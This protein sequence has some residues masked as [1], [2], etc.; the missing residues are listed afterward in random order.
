MV[1]KIDREGPVP[2]SQQLANHLRELILSGAI[3]VGRRIPSLMEL[4]EETGLAR[5]TIQ[6][7]TQV[8]KDEGLIETV[9]GMGLYVVDQTDR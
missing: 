1:I 2:P 6:K 8:L 3:P 4:E 7:A 9:P 5:I